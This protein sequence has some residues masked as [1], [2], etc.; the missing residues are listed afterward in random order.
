MNGKL[1]GDDIINYYLHIR[2]E[3]SRTESWQIAKLYNIYIYS[4]LLIRSSNFHCSVW[5]LFYNFYCI[6]LNLDWIR[7]IGPSVYRYSPDWTYRSPVLGPKG[8]TCVFQFPGKGSIFW[9]LI[10]SNSPKGVWCM[11]VFIRTSFPS[12]TKRKVRR[13][14]DRGQN[15]EQ[16]SQGK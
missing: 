12:P 8:A 4:L 9:L 11:G 7:S 13:R 5:N 10:L 6:N 14:I 15:L 3:C 16:S 2:I 1:W